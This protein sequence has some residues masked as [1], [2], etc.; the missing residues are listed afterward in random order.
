MLAVSHSESAAIALALVANNV[1]KIELAT[2]SM[3]D[4]LIE[5]TA[6]A[7]DLEGERRGIVIGTDQA[8]AAA[9]AAAAEKK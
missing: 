7:S 2:N 3:K 6:K 4:A 5:S 9:A 1:Q 8:A